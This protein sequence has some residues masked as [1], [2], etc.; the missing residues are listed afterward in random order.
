ML[1]IAV[2]QAALGFTTGLCDAVVN[3]FTP[4]VCKTVSRRVIVDCVDE[5][6]GEQK[7]EKKDEKRE[8]D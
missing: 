3:G 5:G 8:H 6:V 7:G 1:L 2:G 4:A